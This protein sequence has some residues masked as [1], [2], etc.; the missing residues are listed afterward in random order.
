MIG[1]KPS[2]GGGAAAA[3]GALAVLPDTGHLITPAAVQ[4]TISFFEHL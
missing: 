1:M 2:A 4:T 3:A